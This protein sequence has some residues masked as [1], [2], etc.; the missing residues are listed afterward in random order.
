MA[1]HKEKIQNDLKEAMRSHDELRLSVLRMLSSAIH[2]KELE[3]RAKSGKTEELIEEEIVA[4]IRSE[5][6][7]R[8]DAVV[9]FQ[10]GG[11]AEAAEKEAAEA[12]ILEAYLPAELSDEEIEKAVKEVI[13]GIGAVTQKDF[14]KIMG[15]SMKRLKWQA[16]GGRVATAVKRGLQQ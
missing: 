12:K 7:K 10:K 15:E 9:G 3:K 13:M 8:R 5:I 4:V 6:K 14:G 16:G 11:R 2:N 1:L